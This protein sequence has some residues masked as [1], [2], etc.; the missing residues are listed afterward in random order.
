[1]LNSKW[2]VEIIAWIMAALIAVL[3]VYPVSSNV[4]DY[5]YTTINTLCVLVFLA[6]SRYILFTKYTPFSHYTPFKLALILSCI[7]LFFY[8]MDSL[9]DFQRMLDEVGLEPNV[10]S[11]DP[12][13]R[14]NIARYGKYQFLFFASGTMLTLFL[15]PI[16][17]VISIWRT[18]NTNNV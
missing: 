15:L 14:W 13:F 10:N 3:V 6:F 17:M 7:P 4:I 8:F 2:T 18:K 5:K 11:D 12:E 9:Y 16:R 1:M